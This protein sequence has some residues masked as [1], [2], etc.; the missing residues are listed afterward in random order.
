MTL[1]L[2]DGRQV[3]FN[4]FREKGWLKVQ[5]CGGGLLVQMTPDQAE[6]FFLQAWQEIRRAKRA[7]PGES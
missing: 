2:G 1:D 4:A 5:S 7:K 3:S 6:E